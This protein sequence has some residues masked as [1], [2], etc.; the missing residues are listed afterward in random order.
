MTKKLENTL[1]YLGK[2]LM[3]I[4]LM[5]SVKN[6]LVLSDYYLLHS[7]SISKLKNSYGVLGFWGQNVRARVQLCITVI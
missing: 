2:R 3:K 1:I 4:I 6:L 7:L 5:K